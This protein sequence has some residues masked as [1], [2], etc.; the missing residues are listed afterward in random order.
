MNFQTCKGTTCA[1]T[2]NAI[3]LP[4]DTK[5]SLIRYM[6]AEIHASLKIHVCPKNPGLPRPIQSCCFWMGFST[7]NP[8]IFPE[9]S[10]FLGHMQNQPKT[11]FGPLFLK[12]PNDPTLPKTRPKFQSK[13]GSFGFYDNLDVH[14]QKYIL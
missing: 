10:G 12:G 5:K 7:I 3:S 11:P 4:R 9:G 1:C 8:T 6:F 13:Q 2:S 14:I